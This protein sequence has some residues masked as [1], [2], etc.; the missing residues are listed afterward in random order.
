MCFLVSAGAVLVT[1][2]RYAPYPATLLS[3]SQAQ[4]VRRNLF[5]TTIPITRSTTIERPDDHG[6]PEAAYNQPD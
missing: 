6:P 3:K 4:P 2:F 5:S 1:L